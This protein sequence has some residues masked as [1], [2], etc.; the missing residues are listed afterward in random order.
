MHKIFTCIIFWLMYTPIETIFETR[1]S[2]RYI[3][4]FSSNPNSQ[5]NT[6]NIKGNF[7]HWLLFLSQWTR[8]SKT[9]LNSKWSRNITNGG[10]FIDVPVVLKKKLKLCNRF[11]SVWID[12]SEGLSEALWNWCREYMYVCALKTGTVWEWHFGVITHSVTIGRHDDFVI[13]YKKNN[14]TRFT[15]YL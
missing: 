3:C 14:C 8:E 2:A 12:P 4:R 6:T 1:L 9:Y 10:I 13:C 7:F 15:L 11:Q 5:K